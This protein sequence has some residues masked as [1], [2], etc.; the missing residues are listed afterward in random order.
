MPT[1]KKSYCFTLNNYTEEEYTKLINVCENEST[2]SILGKEV[3]E[4]GTPHI[5]G[6]IIFKRS[7]HFQTIKNRYFP[8]CHIEIAAGSPSD[9]RRYCSKDGDFREFGEIPKSKRTRDELFVEFTSKL[10]RGTIGM[11]E[12]AAENPGA[13]GFSGHT[14]LRN[15]LSVQPP[16][17]RPNINVKWYWGKPGTGKSRR[18]HEEAPE[19]YVKDPRTKW[20]NG[21][22]LEKCV[23]IDDFAPEGINMNHLL[24]WFDR[25]K[26]YV[27]SK[28]G[29]IPLYAEIFIVTSNFQPC[30]CFIDKFGVN[31]PQLP[32]LERRIVISE[33]L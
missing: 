7:Y 10:G 4:S 20:W 12:F 24:R 3:G 31:H 21:Y 2:Y 13:W 6:Y 27:E 11:V 14:L 29:M 30:E 25:Y 17:D 33:I 19:A 9:S 26:C 15:Y 8:R 22:A 16:I 18:A 28:G 23:I 32:A 1:P 5:Q